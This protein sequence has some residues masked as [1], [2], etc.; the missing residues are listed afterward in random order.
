V[1]YGFDGA[2]TGTVPP[3]GTA[4][5]GFELVRSVAKSETPLVQLVSNFGVLINAIADVTFYG[6]DQVGND[7]SVVGSISIEFGNFGD[8]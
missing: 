4:T 8:Q 2:I 6:T 3:S 7:I 5:F 1:P